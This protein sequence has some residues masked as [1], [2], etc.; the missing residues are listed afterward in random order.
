MLKAFF[1]GWLDSA[2]NR[3]SCFTDR[4]SRAR[5]RPAYA[6]RAGV[7]RVADGL[8]W[9]VESRL[10]CAAVR[11]N[12]TQNVRPTDTV[13]RTPPQHGCFPI[14]IVGQI[15]GDMF[16]SSSELFAAVGQ[17]AVQRIISAAILL[18]GG[19]ASEVDAHVAKL[20]ELM[21]KVEA[22][23]HEEQMSILKRWG[24]S[25]EHV[26]T[27]LEM[28]SEHQIRNL[29]AAT[30]PVGTSS[31]E[32]RVGDVDDGGVVVDI[33]TAETIRNRGKLKAGEIQTYRVLVDAIT[34][35]NRTIGVYMESNLQSPLRGDLADP[36]AEEWPNIYQDN[37][38]SFLEITAKP[39]LDKEGRT[40]RLTVMD[41]KELSEEEVSQELRDVA[42]KISESRRSA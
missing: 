3:I 37:V 4:I 19:R 22:D 1:S 36:A 24:E 35:H 34:V 13:L 15:S 17:E 11:Q 10:L 9:P 39:L 30:T 6:G 27:I 14:E 8:R 23:R 25:E 21:E 5:C 40:R 31:D 7:G 18:S 2:D 20:L 28:F 12:A 33:P 32:A 42:R 16:Q 41:A 29:K 26:R 38:L